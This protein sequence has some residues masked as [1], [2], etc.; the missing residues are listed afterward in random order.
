M[1][2]LNQPARRPFL[3]DVSAASAPRVRADSAACTALT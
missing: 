1:F 3:A 2:T